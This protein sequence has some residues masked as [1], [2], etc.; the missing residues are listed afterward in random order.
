MS[1]PKERQWPEWAGAR[2]TNPA[3]NRDRCEVLSP[4][5][6]RPPQLGALMSLPVRGVGA[7]V[8]V[9]GVGAGVLVRGVEP[10][11]AGLGVVI[12]HLGGGGLACGRGAA[13]ALVASELAADRLLRL[14]HPG[15][16]GVDR[17]E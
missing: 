14:G 1:Q 13:G 7:C 6:Q 2:W 9:R 4:R 8:L 5:H 10:E 3:P 11:R 17:F 15:G 12:D 16:G